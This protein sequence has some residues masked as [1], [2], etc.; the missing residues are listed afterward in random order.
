MFWKKNIFSY[1]IWTVYTVIIGT[2]WV[3]FTMTQIATYEFTRQLP[4]LYKVLLVVLPVI[5]IFALVSMLHKYV[6]DYVR[7]DADRVS[8]QS[9]SEKIKVL[10]ILILGIAVLYHD[11]DIYM[12]KNLGI[13][14]GAMLADGSSI[15]FDG[16]G[17]TYVYMLLL[18]FLFSVFGNKIAVAQIAQ[19]GIY[20][21]T[22]IMMYLAFRREA[23][24]GPSQFTLAIF[25][26][27]PYVQGE[28]LIFGPGLL[29]MAFYFMVLYC[30]S[31]ITG[32]DTAPVMRYLFAGLVSGFLIYM[33]LM[34]LTL[35]FWAVAMLYLRSMELTTAQHKIR[36]IA[37]YLIGMLA[38]FSG[39]IA[40]LYAT[41]G[42]DI[43][44]LL[45]S[46]FR[47][48]MPG[49]IQF[50]DV[51][52]Q[53]GASWLAWLA[54][55]MLL[56]NIFSFWFRRK[57]DRMCSHICLLAFVVFAEAMGIGHS[58]MQY[59]AWIFTFAMLVSLIGLFSSMDLTDK[60]YLVS[61]QNA[62]LQA[63]QD[64]LRATVHTQNELQEKV[65]TNSDKTESEETVADELVTQKNKKSKRKHHERRFVSKD[66]MFEPAVAESD[67]V[68]KDK[69]AE[70]EIISSD[71]DRKETVFKAEKKQELIIKAEEKDI[72][73][74]E[75]IKENK[76]EEI[77]DTKNDKKDYVKKSVVFL[78]S[79]LPGP[80][81][82]IK[83]IMDYDIQV[84]D[85]DDFDI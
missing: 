68:Q 71:A 65:A 44:E 57:T 55:A 61:L 60:A 77:S 35:I 46:W 17:A 21:V 18:R 74:V 63:E 47:Q 78:E 73:K 48:F 7:P 52:K 83:K 43:Q 20:F 67:R 25:L 33:D 84:S 1:F 29:Y 76:S 66:M 28:L 8:E 51:I 81:K 27:A 22:A 37:G 59:D 50:T 49:N 75:P 12:E 19:I 2:L 64:E 31:G 80:K 5:L 11:S 13:Y 6:L 54:T 32:D 82:H 16:H 24:R 62:L 9:S 42:S 26:L 69:E 38:G 45:F 85:D 30:L 41:E 15:S 53:A 3:Y 58:G 72:K 4:V 14:S 34:G 40:L 10:L 39:M 79:P 56:I 70:S 36:L 23:G